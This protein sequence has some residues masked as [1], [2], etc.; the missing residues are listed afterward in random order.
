MGYFAAGYAR[1][2]DSLL[3]PPAE[4]NI[5]GNVVSAAKLHRAALLLDIPARVVQL[6]EPQRDS[7]RLEELSLPPQPAPAAYACAGMMCSPPV[8]E[9]DALADAVRDMQQVAAR[10]VK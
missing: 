5:V 8:T 9:P 10:P 1:E 7:E 2:V 6:L 4:V 3:N